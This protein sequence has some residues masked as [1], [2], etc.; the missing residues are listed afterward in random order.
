MA[1]RTPT[2][3]SDPEIKILILKTVVYILMGIFFIRLFELQ[4]FKHDFYQKIAAKEHYGYTELPARRGEIFIKDYASGEDIRVA[5][6]ITLDTLYADPTIIQNKKLV[7]DRITPMIFNLEEEQLRDEE[8]VKE[9][10]KKAQ[11]KEEIEKIKPHSEEELYSNFYNNLLDSISQEVRQEILLSDD[12]LPDIAI[13]EIENLHIPGFEIKQGKLYAYP[14][15]INNREEAASLLGKYIDITP[16]SLARILEGKNRYVILAKKISPEVSIDIKSLINNDSNKNFYGLG[17]TE[18]YYRFY[19]ENELAS[20]AL[21]FVTPNGIGQYGIEAKYN[22][23]LQGKIGVFQTQRDGSIYGRQITV[24]DSIIQPAV[25]GDDIVLTID[26]SMQMTIEKLLAHAVEKYRAD[27]GQVIVM[28]PN[29]GRIMAMAHYP[30]FNPNDFG[31]ALDMEEVPFSREEVASLEPIATEENAYWFYRNRD[32]HDRYKVIRKRVDGKEELNPSPTEEPDTES[33]PNAPTAE[34]ATPPSPDD[35]DKYA[36]YRYDNWIGL[37]AYQNKIVAAP[38]E[39][40]SVFKAITMSSAIDDKDVTPQTSFQDPG[41]MFLDQNQYGRVTGPDGLRYDYQIGNVSS[42][43][44]GYVTMVRVIEYSCNTG[45]GWVAKKMGKNL[46]YSYMM[47]FGF[48]DRTGIEFDN[49][50]TGQIEHFSQWTESELV[51]HAFGQGITTTPLQMATAYSALANGGILM[52]PHVVEKI[53]QRK[54]KTFETETTPVHRVIDEDTSTK[55]TAMLVSAVENGVAKNAAVPDHYIAAKTGTSQ[56]Y[57]NGKPLSGAG[58]T[59][60][61]IAGF[62]PI[63]NPKFVILVKF[64]RPHTSEWADS[65]AAFLFKDIAAYLY[66]YLGVPPDKQ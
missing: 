31:A 40:G 22:T 62:G 26:R 56:T 14:P 48:G 43:C 66:E 55:I 8:R 27:S 44:T 37:E 2:N 19:P 41:I 38:Y 10:Q 28:D 52:Q 7:A 60:T 51:T 46:F 33:D 34:T 23:Q 35:Y 4:I 54:G 12:I 64:D 5:T 42:Q 9:E 13:Q 3:L 32:A 45:V 36:Y 15:Q 17:L 30:S 21:G 24:G 16:T 50:N 61:S 6:N 58:T 20:N 57:K 53:I 25:D 39:P 18:E 1:R 49:E 63:D 11:T 47:K 29:T 65:T 59:I